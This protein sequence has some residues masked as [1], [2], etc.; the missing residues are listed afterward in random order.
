MYRNTH[1]GCLAITLIAML[2]LAGCRKSDNPVSPPSGSNLTPPV[3]LAQIEDFS[4]NR[5]EPLLFDAGRSHDEDDDYS[6]IMQWEWDWNNDGTYDK[7]GALQWHY[8]TTSGT[9]H[10]QLRVTDDEGETATLATP[11]E[12]TVS[13]G[14]FVVDFPDLYLE[15]LI[16]S[17]VNVPEP[18]DIMFSDLQGLES[19]QCFNTGV[20]DL[21]GLNYCK[22]LTWLSLQQCLTEDLRPL[23]TL[24]RLDYL[25][26]INGDFWDLDPLGY[27]TELT[28]LWLENQACNNVAPLRHCTKLTELTY[29]DQNG[30][31]GF[32]QLGSLTRLEKLR[33]DAFGITTTAPLRQMTHL[34]TLDINGNPI[35]NLDFISHMPN[36]RGLTADNC[37]ITNPAPAFSQALTSVKLGGNPLNSIASIG[38]M[39]SLTHLWLDNC[40]LSNLASLDGL[41]NLEFL[42]VIGNPVTSIAALT[43]LPRIHKLYLYDCQITNICPLLDL[44]GLGVETGEP[45]DPD[46]LYVRGNPLSAASHDVCIPDLEDMGVVVHLD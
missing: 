37:N 46:C 40:G 44:E 2:V 3:P 1:R 28:L 13:A 43:S 41:P 5:Y 17:T 15:E 32:D 19:L 18:I 8:F 12:F 26:A 4:P 27:C 9:H 30:C 21:T 33:L 31:D 36:L 14:D 22:D 35:G 7:T 20:A 42:N 16:R 11:L 25:L 24:S 39:T 10:V 6:Q 34:I 23:M 29:T 38:G 45:G